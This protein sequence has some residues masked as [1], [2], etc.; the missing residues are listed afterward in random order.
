[1][2]CE[3]ASK[4]TY[5]IATNT[6]ETSFQHATESVRNAIKRVLNTKHVATMTSLPVELVDAHAQTGNTWKFFMKDRGCQ[7]FNISGKCIGLVWLSVFRMILLNCK[8]TKRIIC[9]AFNSAE[10]E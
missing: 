8:N 9:S 2:Q 3:E 6:E 1:M 4:D 7:T 5:E 10:I